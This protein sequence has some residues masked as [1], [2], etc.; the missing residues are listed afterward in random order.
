[1]PVMYK[2]IIV[3]GVGGFLLLLAVS[4]GLQAAL[5]PNDAQRPQ[6][7]RTLSPF[8]GARAYA[9]LKAIVALGPRVVGT[10]GGEKTRAYIQQELEAAEVPVLTFPFK[11]DTPLGTRRMVNVVGVVEGTEPG[12]I[13]LSNHYDTKYMPD[14]PF[15]GAN[16][17]GSTTAWMLEMARALGSEREGHTVWLTFFDGEEA[18]GKWTDSDSLYGSRRFVERLKSDGE[19]NQIEALINVDMIGDC[20]LGVFRD[21]GAPDWLQGAVL[22]TAMLI[23]YSQHF[24]QYAPSIQDDHIPFRKAGVPSLNLIDFRYGGSPLNHRRNW[25]TVNDTIDRVC[26]ES[27]QVLGDVLYR[28]LPE[29][30]LRIRTRRAA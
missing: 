4:F 12:I 29:I 21:A 9:D 25:H 19:L 11:V 30:D 7:H 28:A 20:Y 1:M 8:D 3:I 23:G 2:A 24:I 14:I 22:N 13:I 18:F 26:L 16:D 27:L 5:S 15:V 17:G 10:E 6:V